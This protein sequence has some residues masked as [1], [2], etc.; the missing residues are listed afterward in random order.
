MQVSAIKMLRDNLVA[1]HIGEYLNATKHVGM[2][3]Q[4]LQGCNLRINSLLLL[5]RQFRPSV[6]FHLAH[7]MCLRRLTKPV[8][9]AVLLVLAVDQDLGHLVQISEV[10]L[11]VLH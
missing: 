7:F 8:F 10:G 5:L 6:N 1:F 4:R 2:L 3:R 9:T 11:W